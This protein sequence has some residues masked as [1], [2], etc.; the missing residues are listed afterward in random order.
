MI[1]CLGA[2][3]GYHRGHLSLFDR[4]RNL[5]EERGTTWRI[6]TFSPHPRFVL[7]GLKARL[8]SEDE[9]ALLRRCLDLPEPVK[10]PFTREFS[11]M[12]PALFLR[13]LQSAYD[14]EGIVVGRTFRFGRKRSGDSV[15][16]TQYCRE[17]RIALE[18][19][20]QMVMPDGTVISSTSARSMVQAG[21][22]EQVSS[23]LGYPYFMMA[24]VRH[25]E[26]RGH[27]LGY[28]TANILPD[29]KK[30]I[31]AEGVYAGALYSGGAWYPAAVSVGRNPT[32]L[33]QGSLRVEAHGIGFEGDLYG[34][35]PLVAFL[36]RLRPMTRFSGREEL[37]KQLEQDCRM[38]VNV[39]ESRPD[40]PRFFSPL[41]SS[42]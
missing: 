39:F 40:V 34:R 3:D 30:L 12:D 1:I 41:P 14:L 19:I 31:P 11:Q 16:L 42:L 23:L 37:T 8:F 38:A 26:G 24:P 18:L 13:Q 25:G 36:K 32:F 22:V 10:I 33:I 17:H 29:E 9:K 35:S 6:V 7:G 15:F 27:E 20:P 4:A 5:A 21:T 2:F 28:P